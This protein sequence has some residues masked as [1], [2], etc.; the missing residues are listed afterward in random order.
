LAYG[1]AP[2][3]S[4][5]KNY[6]ISVGQRRTAIGMDWKLH[7][8]YN[9]PEDGSVVNPRNLSVEHISHNNMIAANE[10]TLIVMY[11]KSYSFESTISIFQCC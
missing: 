5:Y 6:G 7:L 10:T 8:A 2:D 3:S 4:S 9:N 11:D 1:V